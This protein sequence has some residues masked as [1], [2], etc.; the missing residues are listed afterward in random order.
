MTKNYNLGIIGTGWPGQQHAIAAATLDNAVVYACA[1]VDASRREEFR[2]TY[3]PA[4]VVGDYHEL[5]ADPSLDA[6]IICL[7]NFL[8]F[9]ASLAAL[10]AGKHVLC[11]KPPTL[12]VAEMKVLREEAAKRHLVYYFSRQ[13]RFTPS[14]RAA[15]QV[16]EAGRLGKIYHAKATFVRSRGIPVGVGNWFTEKRQSGGG[17]LIDIG[18]HALDAVWYLMGTPRPVSISAKVYRNFAHLANVPVFDVE[19]AAYAFIRFENDAVVQLETSWAGNLTDDIPPRQYFGQES[20][21]SVLY[22]TKGSVR[23]RP[24]TLFEDQNGKLVSVPLDATEDEPNAFALQL[25]NF[26]DA[27]AGRAAPINSVEQAVELMEMIDGIYSSS[28]LGREVPIAPI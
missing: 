25:S 18:I 1:D 14:T 5:L 17:A 9:P 2:R 28:D 12:N 7:P 23:L 10:E 13:F 22:G 20:N 21:N 11:E 3:E 4:K 8:H 19:D 6:A 27:I 24:L 16:I 26:L 15:K